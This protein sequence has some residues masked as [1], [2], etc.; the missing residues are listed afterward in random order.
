MQ[1]QQLTKALDTALRFGR[2]RVDFV[3]TDAPD[4]HTQLCRLLD[5]ALALARRQGFPLR[6]IQMGMERYPEIGASY[7]H[8][9]VENYCDPKVIRLIF[10][11]G[12]MSLRHTG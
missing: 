9:E 12:N 11:R 6:K 1:V 5:E 8:V 7:W 2:D 10:D 3:V 4:D